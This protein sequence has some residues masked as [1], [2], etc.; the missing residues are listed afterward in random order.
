MP[1]KTLTISQE[2]TKYKGLVNSHRDTEFS[3]FWTK[4][5]PTLPILTTFVLSYCIMCS[6]SVPSE[7]S[8]SIGGNIQSKHRASL[9]P[10]TLQYSMVLKSTN[11]L[12]NE[13]DD[14][15]FDN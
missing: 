13:I 9:H 12:F 4:Y 3:V 10:E 6:T 15:I 5:S 2:L 8:F 14:I 7:S 11:S 1:E